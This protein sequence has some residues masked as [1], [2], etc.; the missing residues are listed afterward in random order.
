MLTRFKKVR[1]GQ[2]PGLVASLR[3][4]ARHFPKRVPESGKG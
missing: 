2:P 3:N 1:L 4:G